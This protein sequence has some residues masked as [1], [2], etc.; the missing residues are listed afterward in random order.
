MK[1]TLTKV[2]RKCSLTFTGRLDFPLTSFSCKI[3]DRAFEIESTGVIAR[4]SNI[5][6]SPSLEENLIYWRDN[7]ICWRDNLIFRGDN[8]ICWRR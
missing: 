8:L 1:A 6:E 7:L 5:N 2:Y 3:N 4:P